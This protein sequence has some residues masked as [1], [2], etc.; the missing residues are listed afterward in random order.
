LL[1]ESGGGRY[2]PEIM[3]DS[4][5]E[6]QT[7]FTYS[8]LQGFVTRSQ[9]LP[10]RANIQATYARSGNMV[11]FKA[12][13]TNTSDVTLSRA[14]NAG[15]HAIVYE[16]Y[17]AQKT[18]RIG[19]GSGRT[20]ISYLQ[21]GGTDTFMISFEVKNV[22]SWDNVAFLV[23]VD[24]RTTNAKTAG[25]YDQLQAVV[26]VPGD[27]TPPTPFKLAPET[28]NFAFNDR[29]T[30]L[31]TGEITV[32]LDPTKTWTA[33]TDVPW[34]EIDK[35]SGSNGEK[36]K[37]NITTKE[38]FTYGKNYG[39]VVVTESGGGRQRA[40]IIEVDYSKA[41]V[42][43]FKV[44]P[45]SITKT[46]Q[47]SDPPGPEVGVRISG[48][49]GQT[50]TAESEEDWIIMTPPNGSVPATF[51]VTFDRSKL[52]EGLNEGK[53]IVR[54]GDDFHEK[55]VTVKVTYIGGGEEPPLENFIYFPLVITNA[56]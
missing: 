56:E 25:I 6:W 50:W 42:P 41:P 31:P 44:L 52:K 7:G 14:N 24:Y 4:S 45:V 49:K 30:E 37:F 8:D 23:L 15:V 33:A 43:E 21:S 11:T 29:A 5:R 32:T 13:I 35:E 47:H 38:H 22:V 3:V 1:D 53:I 12:T 36:I 28:F 51:I 18:D 40:A 48:D 19:R 55:T 2:V 27:V 9:A 54:D 26:A 16:N 34:L 46:I 20:N 39:L 17:H 10:V